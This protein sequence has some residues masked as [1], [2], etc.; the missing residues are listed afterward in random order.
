MQSHGMAVAQLVLEY[1]KV[2]LLPVILAIV[3]TFILVKY[4]KA[5]A[6]TTSAMALLVRKRAAT[7]RQIEG[8]LVL[9]IAG[10]RFVQ[11]CDLYIKLC[12]QK[13]IS[14]EDCQKWAIFAEHFKPAFAQAVEE[15]KLAEYAS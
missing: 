12:K 9:N 15:W 4:G 5:I 14:V 3:L 8:T 6:A 7:Q 11:I 10:R 13:R 2:L 1:L